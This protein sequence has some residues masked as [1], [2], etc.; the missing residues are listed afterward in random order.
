V[1]QTDIIKSRERSTAIGVFDSG[2]GGLTVLAEIRDRLPYEHTVY[3]GDTARVPY[4]PRDPAEVRWFAFE[5]VRYLIEQDVKMVVI[6]C[7]TAAAAALRTLQRPSTCRSSAWWN[8]VRGRPW[9]RR[10]TGA[11]GCSRR[12]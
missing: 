7:N 3:F 10:A 2:V 8:R 5:I 1:R 4:G 12:S 9:R 11:W 6:A